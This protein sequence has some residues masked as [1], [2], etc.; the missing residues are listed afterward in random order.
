[1]KLTTRIERLEGRWGIARFDSMPIAVF[2]RWINGT[3]SEEE[4]DYWSPVV[5]AML[6]G[7]ENGHQVGKMQSKCK[8]C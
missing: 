8:A 3:L 4:F 6:A 5:E 1:M 7:Q 2:R